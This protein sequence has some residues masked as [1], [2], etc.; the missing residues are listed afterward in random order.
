MRQPQNIRG[1]ISYMS[2]KKER[3]GQERGREYF[4]LSRHDDGTTVMHAHCE[5]DD[6]P[7]VTRDVSSTFDSE[8]LE[9]RDGYVR[10]SVG[11][12]HE[13]SGWFHFTDES[14]YCDTDNRT[15]GRVSKTIDMP[16]RASWFGHH[17][18][19]NDGLLSRKFALDAKAGKLRL[20]D[21]MMSSP[22][23]RGATG[24]M[25]FP[26][27]F[28]VVLVGYEEVAVGAGTFKTRKFH[29]TD[30][31]G[32]L[33]EEHPPY[34]MWCTNDAD[35]LLVKAQVGGYMQTYYELTELFR[36]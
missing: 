36:G 7:A 23:H 2:H 26:L 21:V 20:T 35:G 4:T 13:G 16:R 31:A 12:V 22:D 25:L 8:T 19:I 5:I 10:I 28:S 18:I 34:E 6:A 29:I 17:A 15:D 3:Y 24:P 30:T 1:T 27:N 32:G 11:G 9:P 14:A 33:P